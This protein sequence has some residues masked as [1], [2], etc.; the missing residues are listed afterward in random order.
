MSIKEFA[1][2]LSQKIQKQYSVKVA[3]SHIYELIAV[4]QGYKTYNAFVAQNLLLQTDH[5]NLEKTY[6][7]KYIDA[8]TLEILKNPPIEDYLEENDDD[9]YWDVYD[10][11]SCLEQINKIIMSL[12]K[13]LKINASENTYLSIA[14]MVYLD[15]LSLNLKVINFKS[16][17]EKLSYMDFEN[18]ALID[19]GAWND[20]D[21][22]DDGLYEEWDDIDPLQLDFLQIEKY[23]EQILYYA[24]ERKN[25]DA[26]A[27]LGGYYR[28]LA[29]Q[30][31]PYG[32][33]GST[34]GSYWSNDKQ[35]RIYPNEAKRNKARYE[36]YIKQAEEY[37][38]YIKNYPL[39]LQEIDLY[40]D[41]E[42]VYKKILYLC[43][44]GD[45]TAIQYFLYE[46]LFKNHG[47]AWLYIYLAQ[48]CGIDFTQDD[49]KAING[50]TGEEYEDY[51][52]MEIIGREAIQHS[53]NL[54]E[55]DAEQSNLARVKALELFEQITDKP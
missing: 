24:K 53:I 39:N 22:E 30:I 45:T 4:S 43:N 34:F 5:S 54:S 11:H 21:E 7:H 1:F 3:R 6:Q 38:A 29:N 37:E 2:Q 10:G 55:L 47:E 35:K 18:G 12:H 31:A 19:S 46:G 14:K 13:L 40:A 51:G 23:I 32:R 15:I 28:Y 41:I 49:F 44:Q 20:L 33:E 42:T 36:E 52:P 16:A 8:L 27:L 25:P 48:M 17:R 26:Y 50:Y 9:F